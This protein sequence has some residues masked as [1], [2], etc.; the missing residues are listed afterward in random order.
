MKGVCC[1][2]HRASMLVLFCISQYVNAS[3]TDTKTISSNAD[4]GI[5]LLESRVADASSDPVIQLREQRFAQQY[6]DTEQSEFQ[7]LIQKK[8]AHNPSLSQFARD[9]LN[10]RTP[11][12]QVIL[13][14]AVTCSPVHRT[15]HLSSHDSAGKQT[16]EHKSK[17]EDK[18]AELVEV[19]MQGFQKDLAFKEA[20]HKESSEQAE[21][22]AQIASRNSRCAIVSSACVSLASSA[23]ALTSLLKR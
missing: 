17:R 21:R 19:L 10:K 1:M 16:E 9:F 8:L 4:Q 5:L 6:A 13:D 3:D 15:R 20:Q 14:A 18:T 7:N 12:E 23:V 22:L 2:K 11:Q